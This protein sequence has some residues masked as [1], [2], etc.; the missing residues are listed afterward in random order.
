[1]RPRQRAPGIGRWR[2]AAL[3]RRYVS[4]ASQGVSTPHPRLQRR[5]G[6]PESIGAARQVGDRRL[7]EKGGGRWK[8]S[9]EKGPPVSALAAADNPRLKTSAYRAAPAMEVV[10]HHKQWNNT[11][12]TG[13]TH[14]LLVTS[15]HFDA[16]RGKK[17]L[18]A[19]ENAAA[20]GTA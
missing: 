12:T 7:V 4:L 5:P 19:T 18:C 2:L 10:F 13:L 3:A 1:M 11:A 15:R 20:S 9:D 17:L 16:R 6:N 14:Y 8:P